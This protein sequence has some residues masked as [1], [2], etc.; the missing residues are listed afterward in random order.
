MAASGRSRVG[1]CDV[2]CIRS[3]GK[4]GIFQKIYCFQ[5]SKRTGREACQIHLVNILLDPFPMDKVKRLSTRVLNLN[6]QVKGQRGKHQLPLR[7]DK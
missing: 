5:L 1:G 6:K 4:K 7:N 3:I 2:T